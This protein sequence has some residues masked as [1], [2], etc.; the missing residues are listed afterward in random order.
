[1]KFG[2]QILAAATTSTSLCPEDQWLDYKQLKK[3]IKKIPQ[4][5]RDSSVQRSNQRQLLNGSEDERKFFLLLRKEL[6]KVS[7]CFRDLEYKAL[8]KL[9]MLKAEYGR[10]VGS[11]SIT[12]LNYTE[13]LKACTKMHMDL[14]MLENFAVLNY[15]GFTKIL[16][17]HD[18]VTGFSTK[19]QFLLKLVNSEPFAVHPWLRS[20]I[21]SVEEQFQN[22]DMIAN[23]QKSRLAGSMSPPSNTS[24]VQ[25]SSLSPQ[26]GD[27]LRP[28]LG[29]GA[30]DDAMDVQTQINGVAVKH[31]ASGSQNKQQLLNT[32]SSIKKQ[33]ENG[34]SSSSS[35]VFHSTNPE[36]HKQLIQYHSQLESGK[37]TGWLR[38]AYDR[39]NIYEN[40][41]VGSSNQQQQQP[42]QNK[43]PG[44]ILSQSVDSRHND[45]NNS[46]EGE[47]PETQTRQ[48]AGPFSL[49]KTLDTL[50]MLAQQAQSRTPSPSSRNSSKMSTIFEK[51]H[52]AGMTMKQSPTLKGSIDNGLPA[53]NKRAGS[54]LEDEVP[55]KIKKRG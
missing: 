23:V 12:P 35:L 55:R 41:Q 16:K 26:T 32:A 27:F 6:K 7:S 30:P 18:K 4:T 8:R 42:R 45:S 39:A 44:S 13:L 48:Q 51:S 1:M 25:Q 49:S 40:M 5:V 46:E 54:S 53:T 37:G 36:F 34:A 38:N 10:R 29:T 52:V 15:A 19:E 3:L 24:R 2:K 20:A 31:L 28:A 47:G 11:N 17:K 43:R 9:V 21:K 33:I 14:L 22:V 50:A